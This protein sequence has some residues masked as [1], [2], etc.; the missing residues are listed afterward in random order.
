M[1]KKEEYVEIDLLQLFRAL[2]HRAWLIILAALL[3]GAMAFAYTQ[4]LVTPLY[5]AR[6]LMYVNNNSI[7][8]GSTQ[9]SISQGDLTAAQSLVDTYTIILGTRTTLN[10]VIEKANLNYSYEQL[11]KMISAAAVNSTE[12]FY[13]EV[14][15]PD[16]AEAE[17]I[18]NT[19]GQVLP[20]KISAIVDGSSVRLVDYAKV[21]ARPSSPNAMKNAL[22]GALV[23]MVISCAAII[24][25]QLM[26]DK[27]TGPDYLVQNYDIPVLAVIPELTS[28]RSGSGYYGNRYSQ[29]GKGQ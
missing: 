21:P 15:S 20:E 14:T 25:K 8:L 28:G 19:I 10:D 3:T 13:I 1:E 18:A 12:I 27:V 2:L 9:V 22:L 11:S 23:G 6:T 16:P 29:A 5:K 17:L 7:S 4:F 24:I 26:N